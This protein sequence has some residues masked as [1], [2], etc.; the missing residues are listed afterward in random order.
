MT[1]TSMIL[2]GA[3]SLLVSV[4]CRRAY[5]VIIVTFLIIGGIWALI[6]LLGAI[7]GAVFD[8][9]S[10]RPWLVF[11]SYCN[12]YF[13]LITATETLMSPGRVAWSAPWFWQCDALLMLVASGIILGF[14]TLRV[15]TVALRQACGEMRPVKRLVDKGPVRSVTGPLRIMTGCPVL[16]K[17]MRGPLL[18]RHPILARMGIGLLLLTLIVIYVALAIENHISDEWVHVAFSVCLMGLASV[19]SAVVPATVITS[20]KESRSWP[21]LLVTQGR[22]AILGNLR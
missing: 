16:W 9:Y 14:T 5:V 19:F 17:E 4:Y 20:E 12:P 8:M 10:E 2:V 11:F 21:I 18:G 6:P 13:S 22:R 3:I 15:R 1:L 7:P